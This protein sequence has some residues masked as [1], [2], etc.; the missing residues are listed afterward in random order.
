[1][2]FEIVYLGGSNR[3]TFHAC[4]DHEDLIPR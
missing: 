2:P 4:Q 1:V 3:L